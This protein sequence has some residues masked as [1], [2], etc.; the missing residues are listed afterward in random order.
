MTTLELGSFEL[1]D[2]VQQELTSGER[3][4]WFEPTPLAFFD[5][6]DAASVAGLINQ[7]TGGQSQ[8]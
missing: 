2:A 6:P 4:L 7:H 5:V 3:I 1:Q 8:R